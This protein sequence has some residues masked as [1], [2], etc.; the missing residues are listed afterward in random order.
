LNATKSRTKSR[1]VQSKKAKV[2]QLGHLAASNKSEGMPPILA[3]LAPTILA[4][5]TH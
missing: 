1:E 2:A 4:K 3:P 5:Q